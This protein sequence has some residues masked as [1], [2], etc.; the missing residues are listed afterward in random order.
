MVLGQPTK[1]AMTEEQP[2]FDFGPAEEVLPEPE[3]PQEEFNAL[4]ENALITVEEKVNCSVSKEGDIST[5]DIVGKI[6]FTVTDDAK[7][8]CALA[9]QTSHFADKVKF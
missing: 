8:K 1:T 2:V 4:T 7:A 6:F 3:S 9:F 5:F